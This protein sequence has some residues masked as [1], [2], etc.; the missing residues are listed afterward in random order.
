MTVVLRNGR[1][2]DASRYYGAI[3][4]RLERRYRYLEGYVEFGEFETLP[5]ELDEEA[6]EDDPAGNGA[7]A[8]TAD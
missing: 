3:E 7:E 5:D 1:S 6:A 8:E 2:V 4:Q